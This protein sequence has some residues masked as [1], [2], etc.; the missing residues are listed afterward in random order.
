M[1]SVQRWLVVVDD[2]CSLNWM[3][4]NSACSYMNLLIATTFPYSGDL[5][6]LSR[7]LN[8]PLNN[9][10][11]IR[12]FAHCRVWKWQ[13]NSLFHTENCYSE[14][15]ILETAHFKW[16]WPELKINIV[17]LVNWA[18]KKVRQRNMHSMTLANS[19]AQKSIILIWPLSTE[20]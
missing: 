16:T 17:Q 9:M 5:I 4:Q 2:D 20:A 13:S 19:K 1:Q 14:K 12:V 3:K 7:A 18:T 6:A 8:E 10:L 11:L 15:P